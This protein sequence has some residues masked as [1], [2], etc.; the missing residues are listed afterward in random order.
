MLFLFIWLSKL[1]PLQENVAGGGGAGL[2]S[3]DFLRNNQQVGYDH[4]IFVFAFVFGSS[5][6]TPDLN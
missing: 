3:L 2:G 5:F 1:E 6:S 4:Y